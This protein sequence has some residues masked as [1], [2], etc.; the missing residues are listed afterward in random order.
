MEDRQLLSTF[1]VTNLHDS[2]EG[3]LRTA[4]VSADARPGADTI[5]FGAAGT[6][7]VGRT[8]LPALT[9]AVTIDGSSA[10]GFAGTPVVTIDFR[11]TRGLTFDNGSDG[12]ALKS[13]S[14]V[15]AGTA[16]VTLNASFVTVQGNDIGIL[17]DGRVAGNRGDGV[18]INA[19]SH[20]DLIGRADPVSSISYANAGSVPTLPVSVWQGV[21]NGATPGQYLITGTSGSN[22]LLYEGPIS[23]V[24]G[25]SYAVNVPGATTSSVYGPDLL[26]NGEVQLVGS[27]K[28]GTGTVN[29]FRYASPPHFER[30]PSS[31]ARR[32]T[33]HRMTLGVTF[34]AYPGTH[35]NAGSA[36]SPPT[37]ES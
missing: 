17:P 3:S 20:G 25:T 22:G 33:W 5:D 23:G 12:S 2:G 37:A 26:P 8:P 32:G 31:H 18:R 1:T 10:P 36:V 21:R 30:K 6:I 27:Y 19:S 7:R 16:G 11:G 28:R 29:G 14:L 34:A 24:G 13:L 15:R 35:L 9:G 4:I